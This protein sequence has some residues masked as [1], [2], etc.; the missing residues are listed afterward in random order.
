MIYHHVSNFILVLVFA[1]L[2]QD[3][4]TATDQHGL[5]CTPLLNPLV[6]LPVN[7]DVTYVMTAAV[8]K[9]STLSEFL[10]T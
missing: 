8:V 7:L 3:V 9:P 10:Q 4:T 2:I 6:V 5:I 1:I